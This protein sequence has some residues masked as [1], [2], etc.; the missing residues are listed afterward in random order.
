MALCRTIFPFTQAC[1]AFCSRFPMPSPSISSA[2]IC[3]SG[4]S[5]RFR[6]VTSPISGP[7]RPCRFTRRWPRAACPSWWKPSIRGWRWQGRFSMRPMKG[8]ACHPV[9]ASPMPV[10]GNRMRANRF[11][12]RSSRPAPRPNGRCSEPR[13]NTGSSPQATAPGCRNRCRHG[14]ARRRANRSPSCS[15]GGSACARARITCS[16]PGAGPPRMRR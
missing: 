14:P 12:R 16:M 6:K 11:A 3:A 8:W 9:T 4:S 7:R 15:S 10:C 13:W 2:R 1:R 5:K